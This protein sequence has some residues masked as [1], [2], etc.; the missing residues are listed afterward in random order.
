MAVFRI[1]KNKNYTAISN[2]HLQDMNLSLKAKGLLSLMLSLPSNW[3]YSVRGLSEICKETKDTING[4][5]NELEKNNYLVRNRIYKN[6]KIIEWEYNIYETNDLYPKNQDIENQDIGFYDNNK[7][8]N[9][10]LLNNNNNIYSHFENI[11]ARPLNAIEAET[12]DSWLLD[13]TE[14]EIKEVINECAKSNISNIKY[15]QK[16]LYS[17]KTKKEQSKSKLPKWFN[18]EITESEIEEDTDFKNFI[19][20]FRK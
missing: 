8:L 1:N 10:K 15:I 7:I 16:V 2:Y 14:D 5:L 13:K 4:I 19:E 6:G 12:I 18:Q 17:P 20:E 3:D 9:N 11:F